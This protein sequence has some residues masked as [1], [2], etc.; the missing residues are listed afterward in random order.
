MQMKYCLQSPQWQPEDT[1]T[2]FKQKFQQNIHPRCWNSDV[3]PTSNTISFASI[4]LPRTNALML[5]FSDLASSR[6]VATLRVC[7]NNAA[8]LVSTIRNAIEC[9]DLKPQL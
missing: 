4:A 5:H 7:T 9:A 8:F 3:I 6:D 2:K 1:Y